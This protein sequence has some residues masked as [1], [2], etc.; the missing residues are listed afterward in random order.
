MTVRRPDSNSGIELTGHK[1]TYFKSLT[2]AKQLNNY[3][4]QLSD[5]KYF[6]IV[7]LISKR[8][9]NLKCK[10]PASMYEI[11]IERVYSS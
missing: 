1:S 9:T 5:G 6:S 11:K 7:S 10:T 8:I 3:K 2:N 4:Y